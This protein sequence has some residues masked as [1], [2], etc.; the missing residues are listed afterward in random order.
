MI[1]TT[2]TIKGNDWNQFIDK[3]QRM[4]HCFKILN[5][6]NPYILL[7]EDDTSNV[8][9][10]IIINI[11]DNQTY[12]IE[13]ILSG[14]NQTRFIPTINEFEERFIEMTKKLCQSNSW[15]FKVIKQGKRKMKTII[16]I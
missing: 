12:H 5:A 11:I 1:I 7:C 3:F 15:D 2:L 9:E 10:T 8:A 6:E 13:Y 4:H 14:R 16:A